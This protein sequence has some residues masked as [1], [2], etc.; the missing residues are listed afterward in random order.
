MLRIAFAAIIAICII[1]YAYGHPW[2]RERWWN[3]AIDIGWAGV[4]VYLF[5]GQ[6]KALALGFPVDWVSATGV[7]A[8]TILAVG[9]V[10][11]SVDTYRER[12][13]CV[14]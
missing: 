5:A 6:L 1:T 4:L 3:V 12:G 7:V 9:K 13:R 14:R 2:S 10:G 11:R 8:V